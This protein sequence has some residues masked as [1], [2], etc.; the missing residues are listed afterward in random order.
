MSVLKGTDNIKHRLKRC[1]LSPDRTVN[2]ILQVQASCGGY[3]TRI[4]CTFKTGLS[5]KTHIPIIIH[6]N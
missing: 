1:V 2:E 4:V 6:V 5:V 3:N